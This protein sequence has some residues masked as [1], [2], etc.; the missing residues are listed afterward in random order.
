MIS[1]LE[2]EALMVRLMVFIRKAQAP[3]E[4]ECRIRTEGTGALR[5]GWTRPRIAPE[6]T[7]RGWGC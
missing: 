2:A 5:P 3:R 6:A 1:G 4:A 7:Y